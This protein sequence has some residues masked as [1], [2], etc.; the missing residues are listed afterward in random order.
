MDLL[1][2]CI[3]PLFAEHGMRFNRISAVRLRA[4]VQESSQ[5]RRHR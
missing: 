5:Y 1:N 3:I 4:A 2:D